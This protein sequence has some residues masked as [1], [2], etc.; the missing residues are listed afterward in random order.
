LKKR[1][2]L[3]IT[4][5][6]SALCLTCDIFDDLGPNPK[7]PTRISALYV[8]PSQQVGAGDTVSVRAVIIPGEDYDSERFS[9]AWGVDPGVAPILVATDSSCMIR[10]PYVPCLVTVSCTSKISLSPTDTALVGLQVLNYVR[11]VIK[12]SGI[13]HNR[14]LLNNEPATI[15]TMS[16]EFQKPVDSL[17]FTLI[18]EMHKDT[19]IDTTSTAQS[20]SFI[21]IPE[22]MRGR[23]IFYARA[24]AQDSTSNSV[25]GYDTLRCMVKSVVIITRKKQK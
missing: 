6:L 5:L 2:L 9:L 12:W 8:S 14:I 18:G 10:M 21:I 7:T 17:G 4:A 13:A 15:V 22:Q 23:Y 16:K 1:A 20:I 11:P 25:A 24:F 3:F 19:L